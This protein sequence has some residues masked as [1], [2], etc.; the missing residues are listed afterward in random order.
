[1]ATF[2]QCELK[3]D[4]DV[5]EVHRIELGAAPAFTCSCKKDTGGIS[6]CVLPCYLFNLASSRLSVSIVSTGG[7]RSGEF[8][9]TEV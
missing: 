3:N 7:P 1:M 5:C 2:F 6:A 9:A 8:G 4:T